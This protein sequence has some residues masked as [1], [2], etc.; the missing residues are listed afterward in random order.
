MIQKD[1][2][3]K[4]LVKWAKSEDRKR[5]KAIRAELKSLKKKNQQ[6]YDIIQQQNNIILMLR[7]LRFIR[8][9]I[10]LLGLNYSYSGLYRIRTTIKALQILSIFIFLKTFK[11]NKKAFARIAG[12]HTP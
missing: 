6:L 1:K 11:E 10:A 7:Q 12:R 4:E 3:L 9:I 8:L 5:L 2:E